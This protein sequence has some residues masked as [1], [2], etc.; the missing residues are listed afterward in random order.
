M[1]QELIKKIKDILIEH[2]GML[3]PEVETTLGDVY[4]VIYNEDCD[5][6]EVNVIA[7]M[8]QGLK[9]PKTVTIDIEYLSEK[10]I[11]EILRKL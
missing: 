7:D 4:T 10:E 8:S 9:N 3:M 6:V 2:G 11:A 5:S 1:K